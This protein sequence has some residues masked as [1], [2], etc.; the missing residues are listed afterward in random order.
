MQSL[1]A[2]VGDDCDQVELLD[3]ALRTARFRVVVKR[4]HKVKAIEGV[5]PTYSL[6]GK[7][8]RYDVYALKKLA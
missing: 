8:I 7:Q 5:E 3:V 2:L 1:Q 4:H 6:Q